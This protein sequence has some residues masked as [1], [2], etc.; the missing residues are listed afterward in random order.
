MSTHTDYWRGRRKRISRR[1]AR[2]VRTLAPLLGV[3]LCFVSSASAIVTAEKLP[4]ART[5]A[6]RAERSAPNPDYL[7]ISISSTS[8]LSAAPAGI[9]PVLRLP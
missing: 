9:R 5:R 3:L 1:L 7:T 8:K 4:V 6:A 2:D